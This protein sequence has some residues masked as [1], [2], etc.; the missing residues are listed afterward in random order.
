MT[1]DLN[2]PKLSPTDQKLIV[3]VSYWIEGVGQ[4]TVA[5]TGIL[6]NIVSVAVL[7]RKSLRN[8]FN[9]LLVTLAVFD[10]C[11][12]FGGVLE[13][14]RIHFELETRQG[15]LYKFYQNETS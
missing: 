2:C 4:S 15:F 5:V 1:D 3:F 6:A 12:L 10:S 7:T 13:S 9:L 14:F 8:A 11:Y